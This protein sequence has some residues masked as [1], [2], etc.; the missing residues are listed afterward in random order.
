VPLATVQ[1]EKTYWYQ[2]DQVGAPQELTDREGNIVWAA[3]YRVWGETTL[4]KTGTDG[5]ARYSRRRQV[6]PPP[7][8]EQPFRFQGQQFD[9]ETGLHYNRYR[10]YDP[11]VGRF[12]SQDPIGLRGGGNLF[13]YA[14]NPMGWID[15]I[16][17]TNNKTNPACPSCSGANSDVS[18]KKDSPCTKGGDFVEGYH[19][20]KAANIDSIMESGVMKP[21]DGEIYLSRNQADTFVHGA[22]SSIGGAVSG[23]L[24]IDVSKANSVSNISV[25]GNPDTILI[26]TDTPL[27]TKVNSVK[28]RRPDGKG[29]FT[30][31]DC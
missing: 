18:N 30:Y 23:H 16:G 15:P 26:K 20:T 3:D 8:L 11:G 21:K 22:D 27:P 29:G 1:D 10:Y 13:A 31:S 5:S 6:E 12:V 28:V 17:L 2:C 14:P 24:T 19:G 7:V 25:P 9:E 4:R